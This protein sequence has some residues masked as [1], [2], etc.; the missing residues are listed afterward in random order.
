M[1]M[2]AGTASSPVAPPIAPSPGGLAFG[3]RAA[4]ILLRRDLVHFVR[5]P[6]RI[7]AAVGTPVMVWLLAGGGVGESFRPAGLEVS[8][9]L[10]LLPGIAM[11]VA[12]FAAIFGAIGVIED[13]RAGALRA[14]LA[15]P[16]PRWSIAL[17]RAAGTAAVGLVQAAAVLPLAV[18]AGG[19]VGAIDLAVIVLALACAAIGTG[20][21]GVAL[22]WRCATVASFHAAMNLVFMPMWLLSAPF[23]PAE[24]GH[25][26]I[27]LVMRVNPLTWCTEAVRGPF[28][29][30]AGGAASLVGPACFAAAG[31]A[32]ATWTV[33]RRAVP[34]GG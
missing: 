9:A 31:L 12:V 34:P 32:L 30:E 18:V 25:P 4:G 24:G 13:R 11:L 3:L 6:V 21:L 28:V 22:A 10:F 5:R 19:R 14:V 33:A 26:A 27:A 2:A 15:S 20:A 7:A 29:G 17:G 8:Y 23:F 16:V 1:T